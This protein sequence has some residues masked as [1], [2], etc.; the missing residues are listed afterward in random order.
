MFSDKPVITDSFK[1]ALKVLSE[2]HAFDPK[3]A[4]HTYEHADGTKSYSARPTSGQAVIY[5]QK[6]GGEVK[7][8]WNFKR[9]PVYGGPHHGEKHPFPPTKDYVQ[10][11]HAT[12]GTMMIHS[13]EAA[14][15]H[16]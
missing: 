6:K 7:G 5:Q 4:L 9:H 1:A 16:K 8:P 3:D 13:P 11:K 12:G 15:D 10:V 2:G 14:K